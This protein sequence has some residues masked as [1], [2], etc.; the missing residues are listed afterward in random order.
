MNLDFEKDILA[1]ILSFLLKMTIF[2]KSCIFF[3]LIHKIYGILMTI[4]KLGFDNR[5][6]MFLYGK[7]K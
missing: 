7:D 3:F 2:T 5:R 6:S 1:D 4:A